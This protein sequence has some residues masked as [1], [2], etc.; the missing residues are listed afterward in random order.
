MYIVLHKNKQMIVVG[1]FCLRY[2]LSKMKNENLKCL[3]EVSLFNI[4]IGNE[5]G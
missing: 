5:D 2:L 1:A 3:F 4:Y